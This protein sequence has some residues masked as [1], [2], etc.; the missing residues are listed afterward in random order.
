M[1]VVLLTFAFGYNSWAQDTVRVHLGVQFGGAPNLYKHYGDRLLSDHGAK[2]ISSDESLKAATSG[3]YATIPLA[4]FFSW[5]KFGLNWTAGHGFIYGKELE[6]ETRE[7]ELRQE[8]IRGVQTYFEIEPTYEIISRPRFKVIPKAQL[9]YYLTQI[10][11]DFENGF[12]NEFGYGFGGV[13]YFN[14]PFRTDL[15]M[16]VGLGF[17]YSWIGKDRVE[18]YSLKLKLPIY[19]TAY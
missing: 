9:G 10:Q 15:P 12:F 3:F 19:I 6:F 13:V 8:R 14:L 5:D 11:S 2:R 16:D 4:Q 17:N 18:S 1:V 7:G